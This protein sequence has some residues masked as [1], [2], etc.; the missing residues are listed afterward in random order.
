M[1]NG[2]ENLEIEPDNQNLLTTSEDSSDDSQKSSVYGASFNFINVIV[3]AGIIGMPYAFYHA[4]LVMG[5]ILMSMLAYFSAFTCQTIISC[6]LLVGVNRCK[7]I[8]IL[9]L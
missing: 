2:F 9:M 8:D 1:E 4:G 6:G 3:G 5:M 7:S